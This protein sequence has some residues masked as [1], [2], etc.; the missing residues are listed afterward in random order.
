M[1]LVAYPVEMFAAKGAV[2]LRPSYRGSAG[3]GEK[4]RSAN[5]RSLGVG[6]AGVPV[7]MIVYQ[8]LGHAIDKPKQQL[9]AMEQNYR[10][11]SQWLWGEK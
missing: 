11:F 9:A 10:W 1:R 8:G 3:Y 4:F 6:D 2:I 7:K 5:V